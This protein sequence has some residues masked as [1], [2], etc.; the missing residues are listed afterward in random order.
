MAREFNYK[1]P[2]FDVSY[3][4]YWKQ[5]MGCHLKS[6]L[7]KIWDIIMIRYTALRNGPQTPYEAEAHENNAKAR[8]ATISC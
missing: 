2:K 1:A 4:S 7:T 3:Y 6:L 8:V 5:I